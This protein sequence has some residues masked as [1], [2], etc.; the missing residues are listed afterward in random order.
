M[1]DSSGI[2]RRT[3]VKAA[4]LGTAVGGAGWLRAALAQ[5]PG[6]TLTVAIPNSPTTLDPINQVIHDPMVITYMIFE[7]LIDMDIDGNLVP[8]LAKTMPEVS[9]DKLTYT[10]DL[11]DDVAF[12]NGQPLTAEDVKYSF[13]SMLDPQR[14]A[15]RRGIFTKITKVIADSPHRVQVV[16]SEPYAPWLSFLYKYMGIWPKD[17]REKLGDQYF[18]LTPKGI[19]TGPGIF[20]EWRPN[21]SITL[22]RNPNYWQKDLPHWDKLVCKLIPEDSTRV[23]YLLTRQLDIIGA[24][25]PRDFPS[26]GKRPGITGGVRS[27]LG[28]WSVMLL[29]NAKPPFDDINFRK[30]VA[31]AIDRKTLAAKAFFNMVDPCTTPAP[32]QGWWYDKAA[33]D[34]ISY[35]PDRARD[36]LKKSKYADA[37]TFDM[38]TPSVPYLLDTKDAAVAIQSYLGAV[39][40]KASIKPAEAIVVLGQSTSGQAQCL[41]INIMSP[42]EGTYLSMVNFTSGQMMTKCSGWHSPELDS[43]LRQIY[44]AND[45]ETAKPLYA[46]MMTL[47]A[48]E[49]PYVWLGFFDSANLWQQGVKNFKP[50][51]GLSMVVR[52]TIP[53]A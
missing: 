32:P 14:N 49:A 26:L 36:F 34:I 43:L 46:K 20:A 45:R 44:A 41:L 35:D 12:Q 39:G 15:A 17:S 33:D 48:N 8:Q 24:P 27:T 9:A 31:Y 40:I 10:F 42:G 21:E 19:G 11:R 28:G 50:S 37:A 53:P 18:R 16:L 38:L 5:S 3:L 6:K 25:P 4:G 1:A 51:A 52:D 23:A 47:L 22:V 7:N 13:E 2:A 30:A 29:N